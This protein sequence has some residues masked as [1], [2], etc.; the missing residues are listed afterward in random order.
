MMFLGGR[1]GISVGYC[2]YSMNGNWS[3]V[4]CFPLSNFSNKKVI[5]VI[6]PLFMIE[7]NWTIWNY[8][9]SMN[10]TNVVKFFYCLSSP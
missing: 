7:R 4:V 2:I 6:T 5:Y 1:L 8:I 10:V 9:Y 3:G